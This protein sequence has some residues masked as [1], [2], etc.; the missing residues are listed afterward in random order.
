VLRAGFLNA[1]RLKNWPLS[2]GEL[3]HVGDSWTRELIPAFS[4]PFTDGFEVWALNRVVSRSQVGCS[5]V[6]GAFKL[7][8]FG[9]LGGSPQ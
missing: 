4:Q 2:T 9:N 5:C 8:G 3:L 1:C 7:E 6:S